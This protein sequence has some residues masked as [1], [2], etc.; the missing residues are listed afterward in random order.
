ML[1][2]LSVHKAEF[3]MVGAYAMAAHGLPRATGD[4]DIWVNP[5]EKNAAQVMLALA[6]FGAPIRNLILLDL[7]TPGVVFQIG[8]PPN[9]IDILTAIDG[10]SFKQAF[11]NRILIEIDGV[12]LPVI[13]RKDLL[14]NKRATGRPKDRLDADWLEKQS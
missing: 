1:S 11:E 3:L 6:D 9:R 7:A 5:S 8:L 12:I 10:V 2:A 13:G 14:T 4:L